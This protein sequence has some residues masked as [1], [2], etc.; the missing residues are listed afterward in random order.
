MSISYNVV[1]KH[2]GDILVK[3]EAGQGSLFILRL[4]LRSPFATDGTSGTNTSPPTLPP[5]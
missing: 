1:K 3:S 4:P 2:G 5:D